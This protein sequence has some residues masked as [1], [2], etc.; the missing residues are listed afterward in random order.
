MKIRPEKIRVLVQE[1]EELISVLKEAETEYSSDLEKVHPSF[2]DGA[3]NLIHYRKFRSFDLKKLQKRLSNYGL[4][5]LASTESHVMATLTNSRQI[6]LSLIQEQSEFHVPK[7]TS[8][9]NSVKQQKSIPK[10]CLVIDLKA[11]EFG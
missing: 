2:I 6:L 9:K 10:I 3:K 4:S 1:L 8:I 11:D 5:I 7:R